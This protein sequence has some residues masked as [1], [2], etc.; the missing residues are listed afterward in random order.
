MKGPNFWI[1][2]SSNDLDEMNAYIEPRN[3]EYT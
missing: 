2:K 3:S 1:W